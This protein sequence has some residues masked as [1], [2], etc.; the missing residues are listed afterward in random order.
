[1]PNM[2]QDPLAIG[3]ALMGNQGPYGYVQAKQDMA[4]Q[5]QQGEQQ[6]GEQQ[7]EGPTPEDQEKAQIEALVA[8][9]SRIKDGVAGANKVKELALKIEQELAKEQEL[10]AELEANPGASLRLEK[11]LQGAESGNQSIQ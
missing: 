4:V 8:Q 5:Q 1:M 11:L 9:L 7:Q 3:A 2:P 10:N 6:Q